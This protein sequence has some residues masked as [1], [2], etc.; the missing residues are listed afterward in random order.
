MKEMKK[1][2]Y[3]SY[4]TGD[5]HVHVQ[6]GNRK[7]G[8][9]IYTINLLAGDE[10]LTK[11]DGTQLTNI[12]G[13]CAGCCDKCKGD[14]YAIRTQ[15]FRNNNIPSWADNTILATQE[16]ETFFKEIQQFLDR[17][18][19]A[20]VRFHSFGEIPSLKYLLNMVKLAE[21]NPTVIFYTYTK[22]FEWVE[23][24]LDFN[25]NFPNNLVVNVSIWH[26]NY[27]NPFNLPEFIYDDGTEEDVAMLPHCPAIDKNGNSTGVTCAKCKRCLKAKNGSKIAVYAH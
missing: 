14:C 25:G 15:I 26:K 21:D 8:K 2:K 17:S 9:G 5:T 27:E 18:M 11:Q 23:K 16:T 6:D 20:A 4:L 1:I 7:L 10:P 19:V 13:T 3:E 24:Y 22:R 12:P